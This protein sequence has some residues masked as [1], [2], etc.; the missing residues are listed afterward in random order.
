V[1]QYVV[2]V[3]AV[4][5]DNDAVLLL[6]RSSRERFLPNVWGLPAGKVDY[7]ES[8]EHAVLRELAEETG[9]SGTVKCMAG[10]LWFTSR[11]HDRPVG[12][13]Q[14]NFLVQPHHRSVSL[15][16]SSQRHVWMPLDQ[17]S[18]P[19]IALDDF[20]KSSILSAVS[21]SD[22]MSVLVAPMSLK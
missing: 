18:S 15:D 11:V 1:R 3:G 4:V 22:Q 13:V 2:L 17:V 19:P 7:G 12:N 21:L 14:V 8:L 5:V 16:A 9:I 6:Q 20:A 10:S